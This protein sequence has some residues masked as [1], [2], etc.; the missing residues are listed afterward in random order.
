MVEMI[1]E[2][3]NDALL[4]SVQVSMKWKSIGMDQKGIKLVMK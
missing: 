2:Y 3:V 1:S 4:I